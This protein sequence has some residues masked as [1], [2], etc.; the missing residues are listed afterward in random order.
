MGHFQPYWAVKTQD[1]LSGLSHHPHTHSLKIL[2]RNLETEI[3]FIE[4]SRLGDST[5]DIKYSI[6]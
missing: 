6:N 2:E 3:T 1:F 4:N 5:D